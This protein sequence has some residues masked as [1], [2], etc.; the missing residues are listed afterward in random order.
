MKKR[1]PAARRNPVIPDHPEPDATNL[2][3]HVSNVPERPG[4][5]ETCP[6]RLTMQGEPSPARVLQCLKITIPHANGLL[7]ILTLENDV[8][9]LG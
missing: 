8:L 4:T 9:I 1:C 6:M 2:V 3:G 5:L 7:V